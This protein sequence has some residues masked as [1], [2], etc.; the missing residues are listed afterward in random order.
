MAGCSGGGGGGSGDT[1][2]PV[3]IAAAFVGAGGTPTAGDTV[4]LSFSEDVSATLGALVGDAQFALSGGGTLGTA[5]T[6]LDQPSSRGIRVQIGA[7]ATFVP[8]TTTI[9]FAATNDVVADTA[10][11]LGRDGSAVTISTTDGI[12]PAIGNLTLNAIDGILNGTGPAGGTLQVPQ[13]GFTIDLAYSDTGTGGPALGVDPARTVLT[14]SVAVSTPGGTQP[15]GT[16]LLP[17]L[18]ATSATSAAASYAVPAGV[19]FG[20]GAVSLTAIVVDAGGLPSTPA[21]FAFTVRA[22][23]APLQPF[24]TTVN[25]QQVWFLDT[26]R[27]IESFTATGPGLFSSVN[28]TAGASGRSDYVDMLFILGLQSSTPIAN[29]IGADD[30]N[31]V[32]QSRLQAAILAELAAMFPATKVTFTFTQ[33]TGSFGSNSSVAYDSLGYSQICL[34]GSD[35]SSTL[36]ILGIAQLDPSNQRQNNDCLTESAT[37][38]RLGVFLH[39]IADSGMQSS[40]SGLFRQT[41][42]E[43]VPTLLSGAP[44]AAGVPVGDDGSDDQRLQGTLND[45]RTVAIDGSIA[46]LA[47]YIAVIVA[48]ECGHSMGLVINGPMPTGLYGGDATNFPGS[49]DGHIRTATLFPSGTNI[50]SP[51]LTYNLGLDAG[52]GFNSLNLAYLREQAFYGN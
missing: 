13:S 26:S 9:Q 19:A 50:M 25:S 21:A 22:F 23:T 30:S 6:V 34:G 38:S 14:A 48:H 35:D 29:V 4:L 24:E 44:L 3:V 12:A 16:N 7:D 49:S 52:T 10:G 32:V 17:F 11:N 27:D 39:T 15:S 40:S 42:N 2:P 5:T 43:I 1:L 37:T 51:Q 45:S 8:D 28:I 18:T 20:T 41:F 46:G 47:R 31:T 36:A 33:P